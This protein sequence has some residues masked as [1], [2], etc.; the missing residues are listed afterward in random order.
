ML[1]AHVVYLECSRARFLPPPSHTYHQGILVIDYDLE[2]S[3]YSLVALLRADTPLACITRHHHPAL[4]PSL[5][6]H[7][8]GRRG[9]T[10]TR[11]EGYA[12]MRLLLCVRKEFNAHSRAR[13]R[14]ALCRASSS[15]TGST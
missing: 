10:S 8:T 11:C 7:R 12:N 13:M 14:L 2:V 3:A 1:I 5:S 15:G 4:P 6:T 9:I